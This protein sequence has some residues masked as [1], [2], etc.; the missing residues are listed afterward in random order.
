MK[1]SS[2]FA[3]NRTCKTKLTI[4]HSVCVSLQSKACSINNPI[5]SSFHSNLSKKSA[6][7]WNPVVLAKTNNRHAINGLL[8]LANPRKIPLQWSSRDA[9]HMPD[10]PRRWCYR[11]IVRT[12]AV[13]RLIICRKIPDQ[14]Q[15]CESWCRAGGGPPTTGRL[16]GDALWRRVQKPY[17]GVAGLGVCDGIR[18]AEQNRIAK[19]GHSQKIYSV[20]YPL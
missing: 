11:P 18:L 10:T 13:S 15:H 3:R 2:N 4:L 1:Q 16:L 7:V 19:L 9:N 6:R 12:L 8:I 14:P 17:I 20:F 5:W